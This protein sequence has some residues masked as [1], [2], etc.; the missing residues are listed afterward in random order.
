MSQTISQ[1]PWGKSVEKFKHLHQTVSSQ[2]M[3]LLSNLQS[4]HYLTWD[5]LRVTKVIASKQQGSCFSRHQ[6]C[7]VMD[8]G[9]EFTKTSVIAISN[10][11]SDTAGFY[12]TLSGIGLII[13]KVSRHSGVKEGMLSNGEKL[14]I[15]QNN[16]DRCKINLKSPVCKMFDMFEKN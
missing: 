2:P 14:Q 12:E 6:Q 8:Y 16:V 7:P 4:K 13:Q 15:W 9:F 1:E 3:L 11:V 10:R 5:P